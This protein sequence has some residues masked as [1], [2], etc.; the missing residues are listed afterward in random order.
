MNALPEAILPADPEGE[1]HAGIHTIYAQDR[2]SIQL[3]PFWLLSDRDTQKH[4]PPRL[5]C[6]DI[7]HIALMIWAY[8]KEEP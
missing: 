2:K 7:P 3:D 5:L 4:G 1:E 8:G 6:N